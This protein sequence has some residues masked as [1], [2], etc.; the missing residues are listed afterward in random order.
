MFQKMVTGRDSG[1]NI[2]V[3][4]VSVTSI[5][6]QL[7]PHHPQLSKISRYIK[8]CNKTATTVAI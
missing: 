4:R 5:R 1:H 2:K 7:R 6:L 8:D 3:F